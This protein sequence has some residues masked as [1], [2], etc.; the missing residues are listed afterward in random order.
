MGVQ[1]LAGE[2]ECGGIFEGALAV[3]GVAEYRVSGGGHVDPYLVRAARFEGGLYE[4]VSRQVTLG[5][6]AGAGG[7]AIA[8]DCHALPVAGV[9]GYWSVY[10]AGGW[11]WPALHDGQV[12]LEHSAG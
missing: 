6:V 2:A 5:G 1:E 11:I 7:A 4:S 10:Y 9:A 3:E 12:L 8:D